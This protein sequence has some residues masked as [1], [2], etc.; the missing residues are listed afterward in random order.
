MFIIAYK[1]VAAF[2][3]LWYRKPWCY[4]GY[5]LL[6]LA[7]LYRG[8][9]AL[10]AYWKKKQRITFKVPLIV[11]GNLTT[12]G[13]GKTP[14]LIALTQFLQ[15]EGFKVGVVSRGYKSKAERAMKPT[16]VDAHHDAATIGDEPL[17]IYQ[18]TLAPMAI[19]A[20]RNRAVQ[21][22]LQ[23]HLDLDLIFSDDG[24]QNP[25]LTRD[26][27][28]VIIDAVRR[29]GNKLT[30][31]AGPLREPLK[32]L[33]SIDYCLVNGE[34]FEFR[35]LGFRK[36]NEPDAPLLPTLPAA[37]NL[38]AVTG[39]GHPARFFKTLSNLGLQFQTLTF[40]DHHAFQPADFKNL[41]ADMLVITE[42]DAVKCRAFELPQAY[43]LE[44]QA[45]FPTAFLNDFL[46]KVRYTVEQKK[47]ELMLFKGNI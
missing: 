17:L 41:K 16:L 28:I 12:G 40:P 5:L 47:S 38:Y 13:T 18:K 25:A 45:H 11:I 10:F 7:W 21:A 27:E 32:R 46:A 43:V 31:P 19:H 33:Q 37:E 14:A 20:N 15:Q 29:F 6:P 34:E 30:L 36:L 9:T 44:M 35:P 24:L 23:A 8:V 22:L 2:E 3:A 42:K 26:L 1:F 4:L 39:I